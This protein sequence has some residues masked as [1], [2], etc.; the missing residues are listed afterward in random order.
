MIRVHQIPI[1]LV[2]SS[3][4]LMRVAAAQTE[5]SEAELDKKSA[6][7]RPTLEDRIAPVS[8]SLFQKSKHFELTPSLGISVYDAFFQKYSVGLKFSYHLTESF[9]VGAHGTYLFNTP[10]GGLSRCDSQG[11][12]E[13]SLDQLQAVPGRISLLGG[14]DVAWAPIYG[15]LNVLAEKVLHFDAAILL[16]VNIVQYKILEKQEFKSFLT[17]GGNVGLVQRFFLSPNIVLRLDVRDYIYLANVPIE[18]SNTKVENQF[19]FEIGVSFFLG[20]GPK[21]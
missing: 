13:P 16:G 6:I 10:R 5:K 9:S 14:I 7:I 17:P 12:E 3:A 15:K 18:N 21:E 4:F 11:C 8:G 1:L 2:L 20:N 19:L